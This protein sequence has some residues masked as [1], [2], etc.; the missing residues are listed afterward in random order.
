MQLN[1]RK[2]LRALIMLY[3]LIS[4]FLP[5]V[6]VLAI[7]Q[8]Q[9]YIK[10][11]TDLISKM[12]T[13][14]RLTNEDW[15]N[16][17][18]QFRDNLARQA[19]ED[20]VVELFGAGAS[21]GES[22]ER[23]VSHLKEV[24]GVDSV[25]AYSYNNQRMASTDKDETVIQM[26]YALLDII[27][28]K[29]EA[30]TPVYLKFS[31]AQK[32]LR[33]D[34]YA[35]VVEPFYKYLLGILHET[36]FINH[37]YIEAIKQKT[38]LE[39]ALFKQGKAFIYTTPK[40]PIPDSATYLKLGQ[41]KKTVEQDNIFIGRSS[42]H[43]MLD[44][45]LEEDNA[46]FGAI[47]LFISQEPI[48]EGR[49]FIW[50]GFI[51]F[52]GTIIL[53]ALIFGYLFSRKVTAPI[54]V[55]VKALRAMSNGYSPPRVKVKCKDEIGELANSFNKMSDNLEKHQQEI[56]QANKELSNWAALLEKRVEE[57]TKELNL[58]Q[59]QVVQSAKMAAVGQ[60]AGGIAH[61]INNPLT[62]VLNN[63]Q[64]I[65][66]EA[67]AKKD[68]NLSE[69]KEILDIVEESALRCKRITQGL[70]EF[71]R[72]GKRPHEQTNINAAIEATLILAEHEIK[73]ENI[74][75]IREFSKEPPMVLADSHQLQQVFLDIINNAKWAM[76]EKKQGELRIKTQASQKS[77]M[78][79]FSDTG[80]GILAENVSHIFEPF[81][82][83]KNPGEGTGLGLSICYGIIK[84]HNG[85]IEVVS[86]GRDKGTAFRITLPAIT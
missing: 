72:A 34:A 55:L 40:P 53:I 65:K 32:G 82:T 56:K 70:L 80:C 17:L 33:I 2:N 42:Y 81:F 51:A 45:I 47:G 20:F 86:E 62:G 29:K 9:T 71:S 37:N 41:S 24:S 38:G 27:E 15:N 75:L 16:T 4:A 36:I 84:E 23:M 77:V 69:F 58:A 39:A 48:I 25:T 5:A 31:Q 54:L 59:A 18:N 46:L 83:T 63:V 79:T 28:S 85:T 12:E 67:E 7:L 50:K 64:L 74:K 21:A 14:H 43:L 19:R 57:K 35:P 8:R 30:K 10:L 52:T 44:P 66:M 13:L 68:F 22:L 73:I 61:E 60:L 26:D 3:F 1:P 76:R 6:I 49:K 11:H 78:I